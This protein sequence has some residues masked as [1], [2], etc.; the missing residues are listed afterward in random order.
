MLSTQNDLKYRQNKFQ[1]KKEKFEKK[2][3]EIK[4]T[5]RMSR[6]QITLG[7]RS[8]EGRKRLQISTTSSGTSLKSQIKALIN[9]DEDFVVKKDINGK[10]GLEVKFISTSTISSLRLKNGDVLYV[11]PKA[12]KRFVS[13]DTDENVGNGNMSTSG[14]STSLASMTSIKSSNNN[15]SIPFSVEVCMTHYFIRLVKK[16]KPYVI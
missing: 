11:T 9:T 5:V 2:V 13:E 10:P 4:H 7:I 8:S 6:N 14:S 15:F 12:G 16:L 3:P 1:K